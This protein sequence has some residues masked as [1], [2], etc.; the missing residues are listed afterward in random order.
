MNI[1][2][3]NF[4]HFRN[5]QSASFSFE[6][7][8]IHVLY[9]KN[10]QGK[11]NLIEG[12]YFLSHLRSF[13]TKKLQ[14]LT[15]RNENGFQVDCDLE[16]QG[17][18]EDLK[19][20]FSENKKHLYRYSNPV[21]SYS[22]FVGIVNA[23]LFCPDDL[24]LFSMT[25]AIRR[26]FMDME[27]VKLSKVYT[28]TLSHYQKML[29]ERNLILKDK[30]PNKTLAKTYAE[31]LAK[32]QAILIAQRSVFLEKLEKR[33]N[34]LLP[35]FSQKEDERLTI[36]YVTCVDPKEDIENQLLEKY[37]SSW[38]HDSFKHHTSVG[39]HKDDIEFYF[40]DVLLT[41]TA[42]QGQKRTALLC[43]KIALTELIKETK[44]EYPI[45]LLDD[46][47][48][49]LDNA[50]KIQLIRSLP[51]NMQV[52]ITTTEVLPPGWFDRSVRFYTID[53]GIMKEGIFDV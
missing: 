32:D 18:T 11:T 44:G 15:M 42:S 7:A 49:E 51:K 20:I 30:A 38:N 39:C 50:R 21:V 52:F 47:F 17:H 23:V 31:L 10:A 19:M 40:N 43:M 1:R 29:K 35:Y 41:Q 2:K 14:S 28:A 12:I 22:S 33:A 53:H 46:V 6:P 24:N 25:P 36:R 16:T 48:S 9:G 3:L 27:L 37:E 4:H 45:L 13:R 34:E 26:Q 8:T 5:Y